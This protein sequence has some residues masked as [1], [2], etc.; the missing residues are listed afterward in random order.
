MRTGT[1]HL[2][3]DYPNQQY[4]IQ[5]DYSYTGSSTIE[6]I[7]FSA[8]SEDYDGD[9]VRETLVL[10]MYNPTGNGIGTMNYSYRTMTQ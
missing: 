3:V 9:L 1:I 2:T 8:S 10:K 7:I 6:N 5:D 4:H